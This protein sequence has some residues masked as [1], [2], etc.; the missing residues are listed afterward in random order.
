MEGGLQMETLI[1]T[2]PMTG[3]TLDTLPLA[4]KVEV[5]NMVDAAA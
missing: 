3:E 4:S 5:Q 2:N 1:V